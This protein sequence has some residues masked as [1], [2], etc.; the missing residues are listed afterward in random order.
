MHFVF[1]NVILL[2]VSYRHVSATHVTI[3]MVV[4]VFVKSLINGKTVLNIKS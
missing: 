2:Y 4:T 3:F 1:M